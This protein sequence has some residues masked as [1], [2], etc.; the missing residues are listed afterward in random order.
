MATLT[1]STGLDMSTL[2]VLAL[3]DY[4]QVQFSTA[5][6]RLF[7]DDTHYVEFSGIGFVPNQL[8]QIVGGTLQGVDFL[9]GSRVFRLTGADMPAADFY[10]FVAAGDRSGL[11]GALFAGADSFI[12]SSLPD[13]LL[14]YTGN[15]T[16][17][18]GAGADTLVGGSGAD[19]YV[20]TAG[21]VITEAAGGGIDTV[22]SAATWILKAGVEK[23]VLTGAANASGTGNTAA[24][25]ITG[26]AGDNVLKGLGGLDRLLGGGGDDVL[27][28]GAGNDTLT[29]GTGADTFAFTTALSTNTNTD[30]LT[31][32]AA[33]TDLL[34]LKTTVFGALAAGS[35]DASQFASGDG[36]TSALDA[37]DRI[38]YN[39]GS[40]QLYYDADGVGGAAAVQFAV[41][42][43]NSHPS[44]SATDFVIV[45]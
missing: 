39:S 34:R 10:D 44:L 25:T 3:I 38:V 29:G 23:L 7:D 43:T 27:D 31:D 11:L 28:G 42:G 17:K 15:D 16:L 4:D 40:G 8:G 18:G 5:L 41:L 13:V 14:G 35:L 30:I 36:L 20:V 37:D 12:G 19:E 22:K 32:F 6:I 2:D 9:E 26:N 1:L 33:G 24:N 45:A 21:D